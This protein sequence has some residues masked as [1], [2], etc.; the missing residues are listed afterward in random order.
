MRILVWALLAAALGA[1][2]SE[3][4]RLN[5]GDPPALSPRQDGQCHAALDVQIDSRGSV[6]GVRLLYGSGAL[7][8]ELEAAVA[9]WS[10][11]PAREDGEPRGS[12]VLVAALFRAAALYALG[13]CSPP[14]VTLLAPPGLPL[15]LDMSPPAYPARGWGGG[16]VIVEVTVGPSGHVLSARAVGERTGF[17]G[18]AEQAARAWRFVPGRRQ[19]RPVSTRAYLVFGFPEPVLASESS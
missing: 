6:T 1:E 5:E 12:H 13:P 4:P 17:D 8:G 9:R 18:A 3:P 14:D 19:G 7:R 11:E 2:V 16:V 15:P 10:F